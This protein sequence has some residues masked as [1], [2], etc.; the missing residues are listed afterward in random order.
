MNISHVITKKRQLKMME[1]EVKSEMNDEEFILDDLS[2]LIE[3]LSELIS[4]D[5]CS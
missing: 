1:K 5:E 2:D 3:E 4:G